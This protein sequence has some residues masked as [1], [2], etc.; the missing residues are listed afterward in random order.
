MHC[1]A[2]HVKMTDNARFCHQC[3][4]P[5]PLGTANKSTES[6]EIPCPP[7]I[8]EITRDS[9][10]LTEQVLWS[11]RYSAKTMASHWGAAGCSTF[12]LIAVACTWPSI[13]PLTVA[14][15]FFGWC[16]LGWLLIYRKLS[17]HYELTDQ[18]FV[19]KSGI[20]RRVTNRIETID[21]DD[22]AFE[23]GIIE[24]LLNVGSIRLSSSD[25]SHTELVLHGISDVE[26][27]AKLID[28][29]R[30]KERLRRSLYV[31]SI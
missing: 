8:G 2:C 21:M 19:H 29:A 25:R 14:L 30:H 27:I 20:L 7:R 4:K 23:Q 12:L 3:G 11:G 18:R 26:Q 31:E 10:K 9:R 17:V 13:L 24:Q 5:I 16:G 15:T 6:A 22:V 28:D 1:P